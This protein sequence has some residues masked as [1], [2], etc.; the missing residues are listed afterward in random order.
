MS[1]INIYFYLL[2]ILDYEG[3]VVNLCNIPHVNVCYKYLVLFTYDVYLIKGKYFF[4]PIKIKIKTYG[5]DL[6]KLCNITDQRE[7]K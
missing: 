6:V 3:D 7:I 2:L 4:R 5:T 1:A